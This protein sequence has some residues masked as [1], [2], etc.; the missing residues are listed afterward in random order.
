[1]KLIIAKI[2]LSLVGLAF[3]SF[4]IYMLT[5]VPIE[6]WLLAGAMAGIGVFFGITIWAI[7]Q[8]PD[9]ENSGVDKNDS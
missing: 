1:M 9:L 5:Q 2:W 6:V 3:L 7:K 4:V 8:F